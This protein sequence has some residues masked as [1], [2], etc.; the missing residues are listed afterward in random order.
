MSILANS[1]SCMTLSKGVYSKDDCGK[2]T[3]KDTNNKDAPS[4]T[5][6]MW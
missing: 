4:K 1:K 5:H 3:S 2:L 6:N